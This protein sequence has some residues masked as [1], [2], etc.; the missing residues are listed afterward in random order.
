M[1]RNLM[2]RKRYIVLHAGKGIGWVHAENP[3]EAVK[4]VVAMTDKPAEECTAVLLEVRR[5]NRL[6]GN[7]AV[8][9]SG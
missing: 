3:F 5:P 7:D 9:D 4:R 6:D 1:R 2:A 8:S